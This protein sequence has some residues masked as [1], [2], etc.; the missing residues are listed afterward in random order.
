MGV[1]IRHGALAAACAAALIGSAAGAAA[2]GAAKGEIAQQVTFNSWSLND[3][4]DKGWQMVAPLD[5]TYTFQ[6][7]G[8]SRLDLSA[9]TA[10]VISENRSPLSEGR[11]SAFSD[12]VVGATVS[13]NRFTDWQPFLTLDLNLPT[14][15]ETLK[16]A[17]KNAVMDPDLVPLVRFGEGFNLNFSV[18]VTYLVPD[19]KWAITGAVGYNWRGA[20]VADGD[21]DEEFNPGDQLTALLR[22][23]Y[24]SDDVYGAISVQYFDEDVSSLAG[25]PYFNPG[26]QVEIN[27]EGT[28]VIDPKQSV[29]ASVFYTTSGKNE[30]LDFFTNQLI[31]ENVDGNG[32]YYF[33]QIAY[34]RILTSEIGATVSATYG[35]RTENDY[36]A[37]DDLFIPA[38]T[39]WDVRLSA[40]YT[41]PGGWVVAADIGIGGVD[42]DGT[43]FAPDNRKYQ[44]F[45]AG[46]ALSYAL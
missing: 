33:G 23:Q 34:S 40:D 46:L 10:Y 30:Y 16:G 2:G 17:Q 42:D 38:R 6:L 44:T 43:A 9:R 22:V 28:Y 35:V 11:V 3:S 20:Y 32:Q 7:D 19:T 14:G 27:A 15:K 31:K 24:L 18:G 37:A 8:K 1:W 12:T 21:L 41:A 36:V 29:S 25:L 39:Y 5:A 4:D 45:S 26:N 13:V